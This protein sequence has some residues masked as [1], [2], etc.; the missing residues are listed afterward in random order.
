M[1][2]RSIVLSEKYMAGFLDADGSIGVRARVGARPDLIVEVSQRSLYGEIPRAFTEM[3][4]GH[5][6]ERMVGASSEPY[7]YAAMRGRMARKCVERLKGYLVC[8][9]SFAEN[10]LKF[11]DEADVLR[12]EDDLRLVR[13]TVRVLRAKAETVQRNFP[14]RKWLAGY[15]DGD[16]SLSVKV[17][18]KTGYAYPF[19]TILA[20]PQ[21]RAGIVLIAKSFGGAYCM[22]GDNWVWQ[23]Q[24]S[25][26]S[27]ATEFLSHFAKELVIKQPQ[28]YFLLGCAANG[29]F[30]DGNAI[31][32]TIKALNSQQHRLSD[33]AGTAAALVS[34]VKFD[35]EKRLLGRPP[36]RQSNTA[37]T[38]SAVL[39]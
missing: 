17:C 34:E 14:P 24:L 31:R 37:L 10:L 33:P 5:T 27:K 22:N 13:G 28:A 26:P 15:F 32:D 30:R 6:R 21:Y 38:Q 12:T 8:K 9:R 7:T 36:K 16:G 25:Q 11:V 39:L 1:Q 19:A 2:A 3:F 23:L 18:K 20:A 35:I 29:N 4:G